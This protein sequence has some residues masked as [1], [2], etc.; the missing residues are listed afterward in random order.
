MKRILPIVLSIFFVF[1]I[2]FAEVYKWVDEKGVAHFTD[3]IMQIPEKS[4]PKAEIIELSEEAGKEESK[5]KEDG[6]ATVKEKKG[7]QVD[8]LGRGESYWKGRVEEWR[9]KLRE[10]QDQLGTLKTK[11]NEL[12]M[13]HNES[14]SSVERGTLRKEMDQVRNEMD[15]C[16]I[17]IEEAKE[18]LE[19]KIPEEAELY[20]ARPE[21]VK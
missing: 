11:Y 14:K 18:M 19:K 3:D 5:G 16:K 9:K 4:R 8:R 21:W 2:S 20:D 13:R 10:R 6:E 1:E 17:Q 12:T 7:T 15:Q